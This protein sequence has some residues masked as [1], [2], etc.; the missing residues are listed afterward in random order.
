MARRKKPKSEKPESERVGR[1]RRALG[2][3]GRTLYGVGLAG[4]FG[5][6]VGAAIV[7][8]VN[9]PAARRVASAVLARA[10]Q[11]TFYG[12]LSFGT[13]ERLEPYGATISEITVRDEA[14]NTVLVLQDV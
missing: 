9:L 2:F 10:L 4:V 13:I 8:H 6:G 11:G 7:L 14:G 5:F 3:A 12:S 1:G